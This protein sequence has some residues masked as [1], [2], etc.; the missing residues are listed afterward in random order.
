LIAVYDNTVILELSRVRLRRLLRL[1]VS[2][3]LV[4]IELHEF[5]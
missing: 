2:S 1:K 5:I 4:F 3:F